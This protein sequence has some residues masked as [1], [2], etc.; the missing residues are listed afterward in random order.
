VPRALRGRVF[1]IATKGPDGRPLWAYRLHREKGGYASGFRT[2]R[3]AKDALDAAR[4]R[5]LASRSTRLSN[6]LR[7]PTVAD[8]DE[9]YLA[10]LTCGPRTKA[11]REAWL[12]ASSRPRAEGGLGDVKVAAL[13]PLDV[14][15]WRAREAI[16]KPASVHYYM[17][18]LT[19]KL[20][21]S[22]K[23]ARVVT[24]NVAAAVPNPRP[25]KAEV[26]FFATWSEV[27]A[28]DAELP[29]WARGLAVFGCGTGLMPEEWIP[30]TRG[31]V[32]LDGRFVTVR[33]AFSDGVASAY[34]K[35]DKR[36]RRV[37]LRARVVEALASRPSV[38]RPDG[39]LFPGRDGGLIPLRSF[40]RGYWTPAVENAGLEGRTPYS[41]RHTYAAF[42]L[43][44]GVGVF[45]LARRM[46]TSVEMID[47]TYGHLVGDADE[48]ERGL[49]DAFDAREDDDDER[50]A[51]DA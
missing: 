40:R 20:E 23:V 12:R 24:E 42:S 43:A 8:L 15:E 14:A 45:A 9:K 19:M 38:L 25:G 32:D 3:D 6:A 26:A 16:R 28:V 46:G 48:Y 31:D 27:E 5:Y 51:A 13:T 35:T 4:D 34:G 2:E 33:R 41:M 22:R 50:E 49:L 37:P 21:W 18:A 36:R 30:L 47:R 7:D 17:Q 39:L 29:E 11:N 10:S 44:A 1:K